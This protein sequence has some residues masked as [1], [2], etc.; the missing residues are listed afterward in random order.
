[1]ISLDLLKKIFSHKVALI[2]I[3]LIMIIISNQSHL[4]SYFVKFSDEKTCID[5]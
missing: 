5:R 4:V 2:L 1:M 3:I